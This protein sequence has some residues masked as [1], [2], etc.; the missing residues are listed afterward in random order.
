MA[1]LADKDIRRLFAL[2]NEELR[3][4]GTEGELVLAGGAV[5]RIG[6]EGLGMHRHRAM[7]ADNLDKRNPVGAVLR[8]D[9]AIVG[10][11]TEALYGGVRMACERNTGR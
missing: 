1:A 6:H 2:L 4:A 3:R 8:T 9:T 7:P 11:R 5:M 10:D